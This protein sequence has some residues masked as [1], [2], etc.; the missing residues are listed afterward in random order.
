VVTIAPFVVLVQCVCGRGCLLK[1]ER[2]VILSGENHVM[3]SRLMLNISV[4]PKLRQS[5]HLDVQKDEDD[6]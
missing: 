2:V 1:R 4:P 6:F 5:L 3:L